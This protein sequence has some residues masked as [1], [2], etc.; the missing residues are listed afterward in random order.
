M[1]IFLGHWNSVLYDVQKELVRLG[2]EVFTDLEHLE[3][4]KGLDVGVFWNETQFSNGKKHWADYIDDFKKKKIRTVMC[5][6]GRFGSARIFPPFNEKPRCDVI[7]LWGKS[8]RSRYISVGVPEKKIHVTGTTIFS[9]LKPRETQKKTTIVFSPEHWGGEVEENLAVAQTLRKLKKVH[10]ITKL[11]KDSHRADWYDNPVI[12][13]RNTPEH[14]EAVAD[15]LSKADVVVSVFAGTF[16]LLAQSLDIP[17]IV[18]DIWRP[19][20]CGGDDRYK[21]YQRPRASGVTYS[22]LENLNDA[23]KFCLKRPEYLQAERKRAA[24]DDGGIQY[25]NPLQ[26]I[27]DVILGN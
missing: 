19:K 5:Q 26:N 20:A 27:V 7:C 16:E 2:H 12:S 21:T 11:L 3:N 1:R 13:D 15:V 17:V 25:I 24:I 22:S 9:H 8:D 4:P 14:L 23:I 18:A 10:I 6:H